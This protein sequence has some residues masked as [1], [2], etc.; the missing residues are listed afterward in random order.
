MIFFSAFSCLLAGKDFTESAIGRLMFN[1]AAFLEQ[2]VRA[3]F[4]LVVTGV[5][6]ASYLA[7]AY[8]NSLLAVIY[9]ALDLLWFVYVDWGPVAHRPWKKVWQA[10]PSL[11]LQAAIWAL[12]VEVVL[13]LVYLR[14]GNVY[15][16]I[17][18]HWTG[19]VSARP[20]SV[21]G[22][23]LPARFPVCMKNFSCSG[24]DSFAEFLLMRREQFREARKRKSPKREN[25]PVDSFDEDNDAAYGATTYNGESKEHYHADL[26]L[27][28]GGRQSASETESEY[29][30]E[31]TD[32]EDGDFLGKQTNTHG[33]EDHLAQTW[34]AGGD[35][36]SLFAPLELEGKLY[37]AFRSNREAAEGSEGYESEQAVNTPASEGFELED[38]NEWPRRHSPASEGHVGRRVDVDEPSLTCEL[39][40]PEPACY[41]MEE[42]TDG[43][44][45]SPLL[46]ASPKGGS[47]GD[48]EEAAASLHSRSKGGTELEECEAEEDEDWCIVADG[49]SKAGAEGC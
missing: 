6:A 43:F 38:A 20:E 41:E 48:A 12:L 25:T 29:D 11:L 1:Q 2:L 49:A 36:K 21:D 31:E 5:R 28:S 7:C 35:I 3:P 33:E 37:N 30:S 9:A 34:V 46:K 4:S 47:N 8:V 23:H 40:G 42:F 17:S 18:R 45:G 14:F 32:S 44:P 27:S 39:S 24:E 10:L 16:R 13:I 22:E 26:L 19:R 15:K